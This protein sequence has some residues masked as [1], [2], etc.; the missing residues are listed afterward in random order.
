V[1][2]NRLST[3]LIVLIP[4]IKEK[5][6]EINRAKVSRESARP[7]F[8]CKREEKATRFSQKCRVERL[9]NLQWSSV[10]EGQYLFKAKRREHN[11]WKA[12]KKI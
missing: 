11:H 8:S 7:T 3:S 5:I 4:K 1:R 12:A 9:F 2:I 6:R 10:K